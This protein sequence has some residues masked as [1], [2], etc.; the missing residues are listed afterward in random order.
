MTRRWR[1]FSRRAALASAALGLAAALA[2]CAAAPPPYRPAAPDFGG[3]PVWRAPAERVEVERAP[4]LAEPEPAVRSRLAASPAAIAAKWPERRLKA[5]PGASGLIVFTIERAEASERYLP[6]KQ[7]V[8]ALFT[9]DPEAEFTV[10]FAASVALFDGGGAKRGS[11]RAD[12]RASATLPEGADERERRELWN[13]LLGDAAAKLDA[14][15]QKHVPD[16][17]PGLVR[18][19]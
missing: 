7:G 1:S 16:G 8:T 11:A 2:G 14:E 13:R 6:R 15:L 9:R 5:D 4:G 12:A 3:Q 17:V 10:A 18:D 19:R